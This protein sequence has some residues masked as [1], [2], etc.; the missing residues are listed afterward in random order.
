MWICPFSYLVYSVVKNFTNYIEP[1]LQFPISLSLNP[2]AV[3]REE[4]F[5]RF[6]AEIFLG[7]QQDLPG[8][9]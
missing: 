9:P 3:L 2:P 1:T 6:L 5:L 4:P 8:Q 7:F